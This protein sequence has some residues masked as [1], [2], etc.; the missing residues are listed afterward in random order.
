M[1]LLIQAVT[2]MSVGMTL[3]FVFLALVIWGIVLSAQ[4]I[5]RYEQRLAAAAS[6][7]EGTD[8]QRLAAVV[9]VAITEHDA[10]P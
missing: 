6:P 1:E 5:R 10:T 8:P 9:A 7:A 3:V 4:C 2:I